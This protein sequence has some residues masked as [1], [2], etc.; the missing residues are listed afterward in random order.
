MK[1]RV[2]LVWTDNEENDASSI[3]LTSDDASVRRQENRRCV[4]LLAVRPHQLHP[5]FH[6]SFLPAA[7]DLSLERNERAGNA[8]RTGSY[9]AR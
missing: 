1:F 8:A 4:V 9:A 3:F 6:A 5:E 2:E 7:L